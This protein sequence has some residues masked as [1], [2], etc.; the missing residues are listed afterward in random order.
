MT[1]KVAEIEKMMNCCA[2]DRQLINILLDNVF[3]KKELSE[4]SAK[5]NASHGITHAPLDPDRLLFVQRK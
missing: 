1:L 5:G 3:T 2:T 4:S